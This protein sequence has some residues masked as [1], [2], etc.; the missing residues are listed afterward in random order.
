MSQYGQISMTKFDDMRAQHHLAYGEANPNSRVAIVTD[1]SCDLPPEYLIR[2]NIQM[3][4][5]QVNFG[6][7]A[8]VDKITI[9]PREF[10][11]KL[12]SSEY[13]PTTSQPTPGE[14]RNTFKQLFGHYKQA[15]SIHLSGAVSGTLRAA[16]VA[17]ENVSQNNIRV[18]DS[19]N[20]CIA[21]GL[22][23][24]EA[25]EAAE[26]GCSLDEIVAR[27]QRAI[28]DVEFYVAFN[29]VEYLIRGGRISK[30]RGL[31]ARVLNIK[32]VLRFDAS[33]RPAT[34][35]RTMG[36]Q[37][38]LKKV[39]QLVSRHAKG[40]NKLRFAVAHTNAPEKAAWFSERIKREFKV[41]DIMLVNASPAIGVHA[42]PG[43]AGVAFWGE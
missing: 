8:Y 21:L 13:H 10:Y 6:S 35:A 27:T 42:G 37:P 26:D 40:K 36:G 19:R 31:L 14:F 3:V 12:E 34:V 1:S 4:P 16:Q 7:E 2:H 5:V 22:I 43:A 33:G 25:A 24:R 29:T 32:P 18:V 30:S 20:T 17:A 41:T 39:M 15:V 23:V 11:R 38:A 28:D 9:T